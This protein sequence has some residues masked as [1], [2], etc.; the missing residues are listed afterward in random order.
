VRERFALVA[1]TLT[2]LTPDRDEAGITLAA[3]LA[4]LQRVTTELARQH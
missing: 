3:G 2:S 4:V 1:L